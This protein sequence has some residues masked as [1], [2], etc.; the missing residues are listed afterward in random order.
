MSKLVKCKSCGKEVAKGSK[1]CPN[2][3]KDNRNFFMKHKILT[4]IAVLVVLGVVGAAGSGGEDDVV[5]N[6]NTSGQVEQSTEQAAEVSAEQTTSKYEVN[7]NGAGYDE[8]GMSYTISGILSNNGGDLSYIQITIP[9]YDADG[10]KL[11]TALANCNNLKEGE[12][13]KFEAVGF[14]EGIDRYGEP[15]IDAF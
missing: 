1:S 3:G 11:G 15:E 7:I 6:D 10:N 4:A 2:C 13:W 5:V 8:F 14:Y 9:L 12:S